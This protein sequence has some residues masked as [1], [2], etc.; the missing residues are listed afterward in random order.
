[1][2]SYAPRPSP[3]SLVRSPPRYPPG[4]TRYLQLGRPTAP[5]FG[6]PGRSAEVDALFRDQRYQPLWAY[7]GVWREAQRVT[8]RA[9]SPYEATV[10]VERW[11]RSDGGFVYEERPP[12]AVGLPPLADFVERTKQGYCQQFAGTMALM[13]RMLGIPARV[14]V[15]FTSGTWAKGRWTVT[16]RDAHAWVEAW[17]AG[18]GWLTFDPTPGRGTLS[19]TY[20]NASDSADAI[21]A[22]GTGRFLDF[23][24]QS[25]GV[26]PVARVP[27]PDVSG[28]AQPVAVPDPTG[29]CSCSRSGASGP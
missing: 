4:L 5:S 15:G 6:E 26:G 17:F 19:A 29:R 23:S 1:M 22:L 25:Q 18:Y 24:G 2:W 10:A 7:R 9:R 11:L 27:R 8:A 16:D 20:T 14:A 12:L 21:R 28:A 3:A 13:L